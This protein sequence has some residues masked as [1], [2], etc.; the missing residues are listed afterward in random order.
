[1]KV[2]GHKTKSMLDRYNI[3]EETETA[4]ALQTAEAWLQA[5]PKERNVVNMGRV[6]K[7]TIQVQPPLAVAQGV[8]DKGGGW[9]RRWDLK[10]ETASKPADSSHSITENKG[11]STGRDVDGED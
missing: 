3:I 6:A 1:M 2:S 10:P 5:Q 4:A 11:T 7:G 8:E 9:C